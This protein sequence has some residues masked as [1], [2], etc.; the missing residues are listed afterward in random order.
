MAEV[1]R[2]GVQ[3]ASIT[4]RTQGGALREVV[5]TDIGQ[6]QQGGGAAGSFLLV[7]SKISRAHT[8]LPSL[9]LLDS[10]HRR[11]SPS[12][13]LNHRM[14]MAPLLMGRMMSCASRASLEGDHG[15]HPAKFSALTRS[16]ALSVGFR[17]FSAYCCE[18]GRGWVF[19]H[20]LFAND[21]R[22]RKIVAAFERTHARF[23]LCD[24]DSPRVAYRALVVSSRNFCALCCCCG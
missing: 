8:S 22:V 2:A 12:G 16:R 5:S 1:Q 21:A 14:I 10:S 11:T 3:G 4:T 18:R 7:P 13:L 20:P 19:C 17:S 15:P 23:A 9:T 24:T 6:T